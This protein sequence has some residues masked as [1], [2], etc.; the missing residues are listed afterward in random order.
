MTTGI[1][2]LCGEEKELQRSHVI[3]K[4]FFSQILRNSD[5]NLATQFELINKRSIETN[6]T[7]FTRLLCSQCERFFNEKYE[8]YSVAILREKRKEV[9][10]IKDSEGINYKNIDVEKLAIF[11]LSIFWRGVHSE[12]HA[13]D[14]CINDPTIESVLKEII[15]GKIKVVSSI[16]KVRIRLFKDSANF[17]NESM[18]KQIIIAPFK[19][20]IPNGIIY[21]MTFEGYLVEIYLGNLNISNT[22]KNGILDV[23][24]SEIYIPYVEI[25]SHRQIRNTLFESAKLIKDSPIST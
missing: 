7:W 3:G 21:T 23:G 9:E 17:L 10:I 12:H 11:V 19:E 16:I 14:D 8:N 22:I 18:L 13:F 4:T 20:S 1:C 6:D 5:K 24:S 15:K 2:K 25:L